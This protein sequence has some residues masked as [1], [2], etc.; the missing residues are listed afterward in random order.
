MAAVLKTAIGE[1]LSKVRI[2]PPPHLSGALAVRSVYTYGMSNIL[3]LTRPIPE[4]EPEVVQDE[5]ALAGAAFSDDAY[6]VAD[7]TFVPAPALIEWQ[8][9]RELAATV[10]RRRFMT[11]GLAAV[12]GIGISWWQASPMVFLV[13]LIGI[14]TWEVRER[15][16]VPTSVR[17]DA[18]GVTI[19]GT[20]YPHAE[21]TSFDIHHM[22]DDAMELSIAT[23]Q[24]H[25]KHLRVPLGSQD[26]DEVH[27][28]LSMHIP[29]ERHTVP[30]VDWYLRKP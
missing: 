8:A 28:L 25:L 6:G 9:Q 1:I 11:M 5:E 19:D 24:W 20:H 29:L 30:V 14:A 23:T 16:H 15:F 12:A 18:S 13:V 7:D 2:L 4:P 22:P 26:P 10:H 17:I 21:L 3:D 27:A